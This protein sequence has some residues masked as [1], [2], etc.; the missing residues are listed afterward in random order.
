MTESNWPTAS[1]LNH[2]LA[3]VR[4][5]PR[6]SREQERRL[7]LE[8][9][10][11]RHDAINRL[12]EGN[13]S[14]VIKVA[15]DYRWLGVPLEDLINAGNLGLIEA[16]RR[17]D[18]ERRVRFTTYAAFW[19]RKAILEEVAEQSRVVSLPNYQ[20]QLRRRIRKAE[21]A[22][23]RGLGR[24]PNRRELADHLSMR[25]GHLERVLRRGGQEISLD[26][27][28]EDS[29]GAALR[30]KLTDAQTE[31]VDSALHWKIQQRQLRSLLRE[32]NAQQ[33]EVV[34]L[35]YG[36]ENASP[37]TLAEVGARLK[38]SRERVRQIESAAIRW[39][40]AALDRTRQF[41]AR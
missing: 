25:L 9:R 29:P 30:T 7:A 22:L 38:V 24:A 20:A 37:S 1:S 17:F 10:A 32:L 5:I 31:P 12:V 27:P 39:L 14:F 21:R 28:A 16:A 4:R 41:C 36:L 2:Y 13:L 26:D 6:L 40:R 19:I 23:H 3:D 34:T 18:A 11:G 15:G 33:R 8:I 35:R